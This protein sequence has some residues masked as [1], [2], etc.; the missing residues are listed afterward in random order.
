MKGHFPDSLVMASLPLFF[1]LLFPT[2]SKLLQVAKSRCLMFC[3]I[4][5]IGGHQVNVKE[6]DLSGCPDTITLIIKA[7]S[8]D[9]STLRQE[10][11][12]RTVSHYCH[13]LFGGSSMAENISYMTLGSGVQGDMPNTFR[14]SPPHPPSLCYFF[15]FFSRWPLRRVLKYRATQ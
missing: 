15:P 4:R 1:L 5:F 13:Q 10:N 11:L 14:V 9:S 12:W 3:I 2:N 7:L 8:V 6:H